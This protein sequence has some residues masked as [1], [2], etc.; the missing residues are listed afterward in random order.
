MTKRLIVGR[1]PV[2][3]GLLGLTFLSGAPAV[4]AQAATEVTPGGTLVIAT[5]QRP[6]H[7]NPAVQSGIA[8]AAPGAQI[9]ATPLRFGADF[10]PEPYL[11]ESWS[12]SDDHKTLT[13]KLRSDATFHDGKPITA[14][15]VKYSMEVVKANHP[16]SSMLAPVES[17]DATDPTT[18]TIRLSQPHPTIL[19]ALSSALMP[20]IPKHVF[21]DG[22][23]IKVNPKNNLPVGSG[24]FKVTAFEPGQHVV[25]EKYDGFFIKDRPYLD[26][27]ILKQYQDANAAGLAL[28]GGEVQLYPLIDSPRLVQR[29]S[30]QDKLVVTDQGYAGIGALNW[31]AFNTKHPALSDV[32]VRQA[33]SYALD[34]DFVTKALHGGLSKP[35][36]EPVV[37]SSPFYTDAVERY[38]HDMDKAKALLAEAGYGEG[39]KPLE[40][41]IDFIPDNEEQQRSIAEYVKAQL[42][43][44]GIT[45]SVRSSPD[46]PSWAQRVSNHDFDM[47][48]DQVFN[49]GDPVIGVNR[50]YLCDNIK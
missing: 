26:R 35:A 30:R 13:L 48:M 5:V 19:L 27:V 50:T 21:D 49:W 3:A 44:A 1:R 40:L 42:A 14:D 4:H 25:L 10:T 39:G 46:F 2:L 24:P 41:T 20:V 38:D 8:T 18:V 43:K 11:A 9:F 29:L 37:S 32:R 16:F 23:D 22:T 34:R 28:E 17:V 31:L 7:L 47:T 36:F 45:V 6:R 33:I 12:F 15:D